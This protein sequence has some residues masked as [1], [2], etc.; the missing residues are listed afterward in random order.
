MIKRAVVLL[1]G[2]VDSATC[3]AVARSEG[4]ECHAVSFDYGQRH[5]V[6][7]HAAEAI[8]N[9][10]GAASTRVIHVDLRAVGGSALTAEIDV[11]KAG[12]LGSAVGGGGGSGGVGQRGQIPVTYVPAR[13]LIFLSIAAGVA[14]VVGARDVFIGVNA[15][16]YSGYP[17]CR[18]PFIDAFVRAANLATRVGVESDDA[19][20]NFRVHTPLVSLGK[21][22][23]L[24]LG[25]TLGVDYG[26]TMSCY[27]PD[28]QGGACGACDSCRIRRA[29]FEAAGLKDPTRYTPGK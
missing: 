21:G 11:P 29:G 1:S 12:V 16:D 27:D 20:G 8:A 14:E 13:N 22:D 5:K 19:T 17:D 6:E 26:L 25:T 18:R 7:L 15:V 4:Y 10:L 2:G 23:I 24:R 3:L 28:E 9:H